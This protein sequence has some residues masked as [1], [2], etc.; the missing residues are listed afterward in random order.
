YERCVGVLRE[1]DDMEAAVSQA[2]NVPRGRLKVNLPPAMAKQIMVPAL[3][4]FLA[5][6]PNISIELGVTD[7]QIDLVGEGVDCVVRVGAL[8]DS[9]LVARRIGLFEG[10][11]CAAPSYLESHG[12]PRTLDD[13]QEH[14]AVN[15]FSSRTGRVI[16]WAFLVD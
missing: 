14:R 15:Y 16:D 9:S 11:S 8:Q 10:V 5:A 7:R 12:M 3:P 4:E 1:I 2:R 6:H 13:L